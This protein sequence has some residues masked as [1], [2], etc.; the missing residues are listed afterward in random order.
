MSYRDLNYIGVVFD[1][2][3]RICIVVAWMISLD[4]A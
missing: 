4:F 2:F 1:L 3:G